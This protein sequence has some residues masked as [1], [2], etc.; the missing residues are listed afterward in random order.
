MSLQSLF[1]L[2][3]PVISGGM[4]AHII[5]PDKGSKS[6]LLKLFLGTGIGLGV[7]SLINFIYLLLF[8]HLAGFWGLQILVL[9]IL[10]LIVLF[11][12]REYRLTKFMFHPPDRTQIGF[13]FIAGMMVIL[14]LVI[15]TTVSLRKPQGAWDSWMIYNRAARVIHRGGDQWADA[16]S[17]ELYWYFHADYPPMVSLNVA[18][19]WNVV[20][21]ESV[22]IPMLIGGTFLFGSA[23]LLF[24]GMKAYKTLG[25]AVFAMLVLFGISAYIE[26]GSKQVADVPLSFYILATGVLIF[27]YSVRIQKGLLVLAGLSAG[28]AA[29]TKNEGIVFALVSLI[30][31]GIA[32]RKELN[33]IFPWYLL[34]LAVPMTILVY[35][36]IALAPTGDLFTDFSSQISQI[37]DASRH[38][39]ILEQLG[40]GLASLLNWKL[41]VVYAAILGIE[42]PRT[43]LS[44]FLACLMIILL[45]LVGYYSIFLISPHHVL[46]H[47][48]ALY[49]LLLQ[50]GPLIVFL[51][52]SVVRPPE[53]VFQLK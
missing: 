9:T 12:E 49:R 36:K 27:L 45:Q 30:G 5:W 18:S 22:S 37:T 32:Y 33:K 38:S 35:F 3:P 10:L 16:F 52:F 24:A 23:G 26:M 15:Y 48:S 4:L 25:Q 46:W 50:I 11:R 1:S 2:L 21:Q 43:G 8:N 29:W 53:S 51:Y 34:G 31:L 17:P 19:G 6:I 20:G 41:L 44:A 39:E 13:L 14:A 40:L 28:L 47:L 7:N 42:K